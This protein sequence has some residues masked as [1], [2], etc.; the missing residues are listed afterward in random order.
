MV[1]PALAAGYVS[2]FNKSFRCDLGAVED[3]FFREPAPGD[4]AVADDSLKQRRYK[5][6]REVSIRACREPMARYR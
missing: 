1:L 4:P 3:A 2:K 5:G 6:K